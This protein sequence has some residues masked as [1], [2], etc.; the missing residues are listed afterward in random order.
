MTARLM[1]WA[2]GSRLRLL[3]AALAGAGALGS[4][5]ALLGTSAWLIS[6]AAEHP[7]VLYLMVAIVA[8]R[9]LGL[10]RGVL[11]YVERLLGHDAALRILVGLRERIFDRLERLAPA[12]LPAF[13]SG[14]LLTRLV[15][16][17]ESAQ[18]L[19][20]R[21]VLP[22]AAAALVGAAAVVTIGIL[23]PAAGVLLAL[24]LVTAGLLVPLLAGR[25]SRR[26]ERAVAPA[27]GEVGTLAV[28]T[29]QAAAELT[30][31]GAADRRLADVAA[32]DRRLARASATS[33]LTAGL[34]TALTVAA[35]GAAVWGAVALGVP[36]VGSGS[37]DRTELAVV[38]LIPLACAE[39]VA[40]LP[41]AA[42]LLTRARRALGRVV[43]VIDTPPPVREPDRPLPAP[44]GPG[45]LRVERL[46]VRWRPDDPPAV[47]GVDFDLPPGARVAVVGP[48][49]SGK[50]TLAAALV[51]FVEYESGRITLDGVPTTAYDGD[52]VRRVIGLCT[53]EAHVYDTSVEQNL[54]VARPTAIT[55]ELAD[56]V[57]RARLTDWIA[58]LPQGLATPVGEHGAQV[59]GGERQ[60]IALARSLLAGHRVV[61]FDEPT[62]HLDEATGDAL[63]DDLLDAVGDRTV[64]LITHRR[65]HLDRVD[66]VI[67]LSGRRRTGSCDSLEPSGALLAG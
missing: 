6:R 33:S 56:A 67:E 58:T 28:E 27:R 65:D 62:E 40:G 48:S 13:R 41:A 60:R 63:L 22:Y 12:G 54:R 46:R 19:Y 38:V 61:I 37:L 66:Q 18:D 30:A 17:V 35:T 9:A 25:L 14:D 23:L 57:R 55:D 24:A 51:R 44:T 4:A 59:S 42:Q 53:Q 47:D 36:A 3:L 11:R 39:A 32:A 31:Y 26:A 43:E 21:I 49:G 15:D 45:H 10:A 29:L 34:A 1:A 5:V 16:D 64:I 20:L 52:D 50:S 7:P 8:V 2:R